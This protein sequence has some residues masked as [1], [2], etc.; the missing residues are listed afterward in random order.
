MGTNMKMYFDG[1][2]I[3]GDTPRT[4]TLDLQADGEFNIG[5]SGS[6]GAYYTGLLDDVRV[7]NR[8]LTL[9][10]I[11]RLYNMGR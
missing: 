11:K 10:E 3:G 9:D 6:G 4:G 7:Y 1:V 5:R 2:Q 8:A